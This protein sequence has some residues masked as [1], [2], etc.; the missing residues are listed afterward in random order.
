MCADKQPNMLSTATMGLVAVTRRVCD[1]YP[2]HT[3]FADLLKR[4][5]AMDAAELRT[6]F[7]N[8]MLPVAQHLQR[9]NID[10]FRNDPTFA[11]LELDKVDF[12]AHPEAVEEVFSV[13]NQTLLL[14]STM[15][16]LPPNLVDVAQN[17][18]GQM[19]AAIGP[20]GEIDQS[21]MSGILA[22][23]M[24]AAGVYKQ[25]IAQMDA[26]TARE[27]LAQARRNLI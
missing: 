18:A 11:V 23:A 8:I 19:S 13:I 1:L 12:D 6:S 24:T 15:A 21:A 20:S 7:E 25:P 5:E 26:P 10:Y 14:I 3:P 16:L 9:K 2:T 27:K 17:M 4:V 22:Q